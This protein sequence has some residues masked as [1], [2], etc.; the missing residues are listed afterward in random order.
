MKKNL[1]SLVIISIIFYACKKD[2][3]STLPPNNN[4]II[5]TIV[6]SSGSILNI[7]ASGSKAILG[8]FSG[9]GGPG[10][11]DGTNAAN[12]AVYINVY[13][14]ISSTGTI[15]GRNAGFWCQYRQNVTSFSTPIYEN[16]GASS[17]SI[18]FTSVSNLYLE[19]SFNAVC[20]NGTDSVIVSGTFKGD[21]I[22]H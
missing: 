19:G 10:Y 8:L 9:F 7:N 11:I 4:Q 13:P 17:G 15:N 6:L 12:A 1:L 21:Y 22:S 20:R 16:S 18:T 5:A 14:K 3:Q 2:G